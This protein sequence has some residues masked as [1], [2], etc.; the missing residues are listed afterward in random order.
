M[1]WRVSAG[2]SITG[3]AT[4]I[5]SGRLALAVKDQP[6]PAV[7][8]LTVLGDDLQLAGHAVVDT[9]GWSG[10]HATR[11]LGFFGSDR[12]ITKAGYQAIVEDAR[13]MD[14]IEQHS[15]EE[16]SVASWSIGPQ[17]RCEAARP[18]GEYHRVNPLLRLGV[19]ACQ[20]PNGVESRDP[21]TLDRV[22][23]PPALRR[24]AYVSPRG[25]Y[26]AAHLFTVDVHVS[27]WLRLPRYSRN[28]WRAHA[29]RIWPSCRSRRRT[30]SRLR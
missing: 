20:G 16:W 29:R 3:L 13:Y 6:G 10:L 8:H 21:C 24:A 4:D 15:E 26:A 14:V 27:G 17:L 11:W 23:G 18:L 22:A 25:A 19:V 5:A 1:G 7:H 28:R 30:T 12:L 2:A 9:T